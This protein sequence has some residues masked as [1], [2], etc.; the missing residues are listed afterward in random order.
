VGEQARAAGERG[1]VAGAIHG[2]VM[3][4]DHARKIDAGSYIERQEVHGGSVFNQSGQTVHGKQT[5]IGGNVNTGGGMFNAGDI[6]TRGGDFVGRDKITHG[7]VVRG[8]KIGGD[9]YDI[10]NVSG[11]NVAIGR[12]ARVNVN[13]PAPADLIKA[14]EPILLAAQAAPADKRNEAIQKVEALKEEVAKGQGADDKKVAG[15]LSGLA[16]LLPDAVRS[17]GVA[18]G[19]PMLAG[20]AGPLTDFVLEQIGVK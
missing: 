9:K 19:Q 1:V 3:T 14:L 12:G 11:G 2:N 10:G 18:F 7:D 6:N 4:G 5:N 16:K 20:I 13:D 15:L 8:D 17:I